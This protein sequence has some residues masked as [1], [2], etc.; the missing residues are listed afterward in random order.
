MIKKNARN[1]PLLVAL[2]TLIFPFYTSAAVKLS[3]SVPNYANQ[4]VRFVVLSDYITNKEIEISRTTT[5]SSG[6]FKTELDLKIITKLFIKT[7]ISQAF[8]FAEPDS[9]YQVQLTEPDSTAFQTLGSE[10]QVSLLFLNAKSAALNQQIIAFENLLTEFY[11]QNNIYFATPRVL[12]KQLTSFKKEVLQTQFLNPSPFLASY[13]ECSIAPIEEAAFQNPTHQ[14]LTYF[15]GPIQ[16]NHPVYMGYFSAFYKQYLKRLSLKKSG[17]SLFADINTMHSYS[18][19]MSTMLKADTLLKNDTLRELILICGLNE[20]YYQKDCNRQNIALIM[21]YIAL[22]GLGQHNRNIA[23]NRVES[24]NA[25]EYGSAA[26]EIVLNHPK[27]KS[28]ADLKGNYIYINFWADWNSESLQELKYIQKLE[29]KYGH[30]IQFISV[31]CSD[32]TENEMKYFK[33]NKY[34]WISLADDNKAIRNA[35]HVKNIPYYILIDTD[36]DILKANASAP[37][38]N[39]ENYI[40]QLIKK[41]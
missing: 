37:S 35:Y 13:I 17:E 24:I 41:K 9:T 28:L 10:P 11:A 23:K 5:D 7:A 1:A 14:F 16:Y 31:A 18:T 40:K 33:N 20:W 22:K 26:P 34:T 27:Y 19:A 8:L 4:E 32:K 38:N 36:G 21:N 39:L 25:L 12:Q 3:G 2:F 29:Q 15:N 6:F 30:R